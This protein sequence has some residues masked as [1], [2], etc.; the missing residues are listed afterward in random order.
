MRGRDIEEAGTGGSE[1]P[2]S[3][4]SRNDIWI[5]LHAV[6]RENGNPNSRSHTG[7]LDLL[8]FQTRGLLVGAE[9]TREDKRYICFSTERRSTLWCVYL[10]RNVRETDSVVH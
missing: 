7:T 4:D 5:F 8:I 2:S 9:T 10:F 6:P 3:E 1:F